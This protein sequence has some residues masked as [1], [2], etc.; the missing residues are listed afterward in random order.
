MRKYSKIV[1]FKNRECPNRKGW[2]AGYDSSSLCLDRCIKYL[3]S[4][5]T[6]LWIWHDKENYNKFFLKDK[7]KFEEVK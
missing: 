5:L 3:Y 4:A 6:G 7:R 2:E 1:P